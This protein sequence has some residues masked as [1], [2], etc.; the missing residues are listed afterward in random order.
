MEVELALLIY[1]RLI[2]S[3]I[4]RITQIKDRTESRLSRCQ[5]HHWICNKDNDKGCCR[6]SFF[7]S[8]PRFDLYDRSFYKLLHMEI[9]RKKGK[10]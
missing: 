8:N 6:G 10:C 7:R 5:L 2:A 3:E 4:Y 9:Y 1:L